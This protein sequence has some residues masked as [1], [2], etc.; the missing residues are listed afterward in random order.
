MTSNDVRKYWLACK[1]FQKAKLLYLHNHLFRRDAFMQLWL[2]A[3]ARG[4]VERLTNE[5]DEL[6]DHD[7]PLERVGV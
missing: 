1:D 2:Q 3:E 4:V 7:P 6:E 5:G